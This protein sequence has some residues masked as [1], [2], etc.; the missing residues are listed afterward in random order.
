MPKQILFCFAGTGDTAEQIQKKYEDSAF[1]EDVVRVYFNGC[2]DKAIGGSSYFGYINPNLD[3]VAKQI[4]ESFDSTG[5]LSLSQLKE[6]FGKSIIIKPTDVQ[7]D[8]VEVEKINLTGFSRGAVTTFAVARHLNSVGKP[9]RL[10]AQEPVPGD[11]KDQAKKISSEFFKNHDLSG[12]TQ[13]VEALVVLG[14]YQRDVNP[15]HNKFCRQMAP[16]FGKTCASAVYTVPTTHHME[17]S[18]KAE[19]QLID[20]FARENM[21]TDEALYYNEAKDQMTFTPKII[22]QKH[23]RGTFGRIELLPRYKTALFALVSEHQ[24]SEEAS[25][26]IAQSLYCLQSAPA[27]AN[28]DLLISRVKDDMSLNGKALRE[29]IVEFEFINQFVFKP[30]IDEQS[31]NAI[32]LFRC[33][34]YEDLQLFPIEKATVVQKK[35]FVDTLM[36]QLNEM[37]NSV[38]RTHWNALNDLM[39]LFLKEN[40]VCH[41]HLAQHIDESETF[42]RGPQNLKTNEQTMTTIRTAKTGAEIAEMLYHLPEEKRESAFDKFPENWQKMIT[43]ASQLGDILLFLPVKH[44]EKVLQNKEVRELIKNKEQLDSIMDKMLHPAQR[45]VIYSVLKADVNTHMNIIQSQRAIRQQLDLLREEKTSEEKT[46]MYA[47]RSI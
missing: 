20:F 28:K 22:Q 16:L 2:Q 12:C 1:N 15:L 43:D 11:T 14:A 39:S 45:R 6:K 32:N 35:A 25:I 27:F 47:S 33:K 42:K 18:R 34:V 37:K 29:F 21:I 36:N 8:K 31:Q 46:I 3:T 26:K 17:L 38:S 4:R 13:L 5:Q 41:P 24:L 19:N 10:F 7:E 9:I 23:H 40:T 44:I 30:S